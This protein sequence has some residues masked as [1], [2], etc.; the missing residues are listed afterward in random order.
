RTMLPAVEV[1]E[2]TG[3]HGLS[4]ARNTG[5]A[6]AAGDVVVF[7]D[8]DAEA[9]PDWL[10]ELLDAFADPAA[11]GVGGWVEPIWEGGRPAWFPVEFQWVVGC[12][13]RGLPASRAPIRNMIGCNMAFRRE[14]FAQVGGFSTGIGR[15]G[16]R[17]L[18]CEETELCIRVGQR[19][20]EAVMVHEPAARV[21][22]HVPRHRAG[23]RYLVARCYAEGLSK[24]LVARSVGSRDGLAAERVYTLRV[25]PRGVLSGLVSAVARGDPA[26]LG[27][28]AAI[29]LGFACTAAGYAAGA[30]R[31]AGGAEQTRSGTSGGLPPRGD[32]AEVTTP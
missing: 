10:A 28:A 30:L 9:E 15:V 27:R 24:A 7:L 1:V 31:R 16:G 23:F 22:H 21:R 25:L 20:P 32:A 13:Y 29:V 5:I 6:V 8:D 4:G 12:S 3:A 14:V 11:L 17:P 18:G 26:G 19:W 2:N